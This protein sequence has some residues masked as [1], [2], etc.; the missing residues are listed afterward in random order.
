GGGYGHH[1]R[2]W[3]ARDAAGNIIPN[4]YFMAMDY[5]GI[6]YDYQDNVYLITNIKPFAG[7]SVP[8][9][10]TATGA[11]ISLN[12]ADNTEANLAG[13][14]V[15]RST[16]SGGTYTKLNDSPIVDS[17]YIDGATAIGT[18]YFYKVTAVDNAG[19]ESAQTAAVSATRTSDNSAPS[20]PKSFV[21]NGMSN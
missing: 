15:Y 17:A 16:S 9:G 18:T 4:A 13:Y 11:G 14:N 8:T 6:N 12:W 19:N 5:S 7:P 20:A 1:V 3:V 10:L 21:A 2:F